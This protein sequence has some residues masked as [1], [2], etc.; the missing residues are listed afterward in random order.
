MI[1]LPFLR[2]ASKKPSKFVTLDINSES[3]KCLAYYKEDGTIKVIGKGKEFLEPGGVRNGVIIDF[4]PVVQSAK[5][6]IFLATQDIEEDVDDVIIGVTSDLCWESVTTAKINRGTSASI[7]PG[8]V[9]EIQSKISESSQVQTQT[10]YA[11]A[12]G[13][14]EVDLH[15]ITS[16]IIHTKLDGKKAS[17][18]EEQ[19]GQTIE[20][21]LYTGFC[22]AHHV[23]SLRKL[24]KKL[25]LNIL[26]I[27]PENFALLKALRQTDKESTDLVLAQI[28][29][30][31]TNI[32]VVF[33]GAIV[34]NKS[35][36]IGKKHFVEEISNIM[37]LTAT[38]SRK[39]LESH[40]RGK[41]SPSESVVVQ[42]C[43]SDVL[44]IWLEG[45]ELL[46]ADFSGVKTFAPC[47]YLYGEG[48]QLPEIEEALTKTPWMKSIPFKSPPTIEE[49]EVGDF[50][51]IADA[52]G[53]VNT[54]DW[55]IPLVLAY[56]YE[57]VV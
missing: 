56:I 47:I 6:A 45:V 49:I 5:E 23:Q 28:G 54:N 42:N 14:T 52:T 17:S 33:G 11:Q 2:T 29:S 36:H 15:L 51:K 21:A 4:E 8:E 13:D 57:E 48:T 18:L 10:N 1:R 40:S 12:T 53:T 7:T 22:P 19:Q 26:A 27:S 24:A 41:L 50:T 20:M 34:A 25:G 35:L 39:V 32:G 55:A 3:V 31:F 38:E 46:F 43:L 37:G 16:S 30:D 9:E 44:D